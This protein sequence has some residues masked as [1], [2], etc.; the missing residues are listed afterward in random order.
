MHRLEKNI[1]H[2]AKQR[3]EQR[4]LNTNRSIL[5]QVAQVK[6]LI[7]HSTNLVN[8]MYDSEQK[9]Y[10]ECNEQEREKHIFNSLEKVININ[11]NLKTFYNV[12]K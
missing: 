8:Y 9:H 11:N 1:M 4:K 7:E 3:K 2:H 10:E 5:L 6:E 12:L